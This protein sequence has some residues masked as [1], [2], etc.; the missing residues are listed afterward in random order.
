YPFIRQT[1]LLQPAS[2]YGTSVIDRLIP[3]QRAYNAIKN[4]K[5]EFL[6]RI[7]M[8]VLMVEDGSIDLD[9]IEE[10]GIAPGKVIVYRQGSNI[11]IMMNMGSVPNDFR[12]EEDRLLNE[13]I[14]ISGVSDFLTGSTISDNISG[15][16]LG[17]IIEQDN[18]RLSITADSIRDAIKDVG[19]HIL[20]LYKQFATTKR[21]V[22]IAGENGSMEQV[23]FQNSLITSDDLVFDMDNELVNTLSNRKS[24]VTELLKMGLLHD[25]NGKLK[26]SSRVKLLEMMGL[27]NWESAV[28]M[29]ELHTKKASYENEELKYAVPKIQDYDNHQ[30]H[31]DTHTS[32][33]I[34]KNNNLSDTQKTQLAKHIRTH[35]QFLRL[36]KEAEQLQNN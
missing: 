35:R 6:N 21:L 23:A 36:S 10:E 33:L 14:T 12:D 1:C 26:D 30:I 2:F 22:R 9:N 13:F 31:I 5:H 3:V 18:N 34:K 19:K 16:T 24:M 20:R 29:E 28:D 8:G 17:L 15:V 7:S 4:Q 32:F 11:P 25:E 27:G